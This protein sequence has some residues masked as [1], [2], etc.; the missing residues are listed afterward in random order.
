M[1]TWI[2]NLIYILP[3]FILINACTPEIDVPAPVAGAADFSKYVSVGNSLTAGYADN[4][5]YNEGQMQ[6]YP[7]MIAQ[8]MNE[9]TQSDFIQPDIPGNGS[10]YMYLTSLAPTFG[11]FDADPN[12]FDQLEGSFNNLGVPGIRAKDI[13]FKGYGSSPQ[14]NAFF[15]RMLGVKDTNMSYLELV[16][17]NP[18]TFFT[19]WMGNNDVLGYAS[20]GGAA[21]IAGAPGTG[22]G[23]LTDPD[24]EFKPSYDALIAALTSQG[25]KGV[26]VTIPNITLAPFF[27]T[28]P[29]AA[30]PLD[31]A[32]ATTLMSMS[33]FGGFN[34][35]LDGLVGLNIISEAEAEKRKVHYA[36]GVNTILIQD[37]DLFDFSA[38]LGTINPALAAYGQTRQSTAK[39]LILLTSSSVIGQLADPNNPLSQI[40]VV[41][42]LGDEYVLT[43]DEIDNVND[44][45]KDFNDI[46]RAYASS[47]A[48]IA[49]F[50]VND[51]LEEVNEGIYA[52]GVNVNGGFIKGGAF[53][54]DGVHLT[55]RG[56][57]LVA[58]GI[59]ET[60]NNN[61]NATLSPVI[62]NNYRAVI[63]P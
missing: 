33:A 56:Y 31:E 13:T 22:L 9:I 63:L 16:A 60:I 57:S 34:A 48:D 17:E 36:E 40:G 2:K 25:G 49:V 58:N 29:Y 26:V 46:I 37:N 55:P 39:D 61:F 1:K 28:V 50:E 4:G 45:T 38:I 18:P 8:Q 14:V 12:W 47:S 3:A 53:S 43:K 15:Y 11:E 5:L 41:V 10:G 35:A 52:D 21:G 20:S 27:T 62:I 32:T 51:L 59:I 7:K 19:S 42:P 54:L 6:S 30:I 44:Y 24:T 23:G